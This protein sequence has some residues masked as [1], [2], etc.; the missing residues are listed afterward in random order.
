V[1]RR[2]SNSSILRVE[3]AKEYAGRLRNGER[4]MAFYAWD[5]ALCECPPTH[6]LYGIPCLP[7][8]TSALRADSPGAS[9][10]CLCC[11]RP[12]SIPDLRRSDRRAA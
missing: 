3:V 10:R 7:T 9:V 4:L 12:W 1:K 6:D 11:D 8:A 2:R 5:F